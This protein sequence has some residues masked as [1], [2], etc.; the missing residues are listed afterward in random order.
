MKMKITTSEPHLTLPSGKDVLL[1]S[2][3][4]SNAPVVHSKLTTKLQNPKCRCEL[5]PHQAW[6]GK[7]GNMEKSGNLKVI[8]EK[9]GKMC[10]CLWCATV[11]S[12]IDIR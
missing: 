2:A 8:R 11:S 10:C 3:E 1:P 5:G 9:S 12:V 6:T 4:T 7:V